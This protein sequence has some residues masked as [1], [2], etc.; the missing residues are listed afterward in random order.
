MA[1]SGP[2]LANLNLDTGRPAEAGEYSLA[3]KAYAEL[4]RRHAQDHFTRMPDAL[5][6]DMLNHFHDPR[7][8]LTFEESSQDREK[9]LR[10]L[11]ELQSS[12]RDG[13]DDGV[14]EG[15]QVS[16]PIG[17]AAPRRVLVK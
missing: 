17:V 11:S 14:T 15:S 2:R 8:A 4:L 10:A 13:D 6:D 3:D 16:G 7:R 5:R 12:V 9:T 1:L